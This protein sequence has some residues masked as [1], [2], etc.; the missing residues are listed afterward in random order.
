MVGTSIMI[1]ILPLYAQ[2]EFALDERMIPVLI[3]AFFAAQFVAP[4][5]VAIKI[6]S[7]RTCSDLDCQPNRHGHGLCYD[8]F[9]AIGIDCNCSRHAYLTV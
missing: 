3:S 1:P 5:W 4:P 8:R 2:R 6:R 9:R 7:V